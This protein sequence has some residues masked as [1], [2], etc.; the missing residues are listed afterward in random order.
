MR[1]ER[2][3]DMQWVILDS[4]AYRM[5]LEQGYHLVRSEYRKVRPGEDRQHWALMLKQAQ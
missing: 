5:L 1:N 2:G 4:E 3:D